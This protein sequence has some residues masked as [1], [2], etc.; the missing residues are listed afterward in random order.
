MESTLPMEVVHTETK[1]RPTPTSFREYMTTLST[2]EQCLLK[3]IKATNTTYGSLKT[4]IELGDKLWIV[5]DRGL[6][7]GDGYYDWVIATDT[8][9]L[10]EGRGYAQSDAELVESLCMEVMAYLVGAT[11]LKHYS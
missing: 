11:F 1:Q 2:C 7:Q 10:W 5:T 9:I 8:N 6:K 3:H 4:H